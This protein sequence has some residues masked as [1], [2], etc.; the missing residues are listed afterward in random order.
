MRLGSFTTCTQ[1]IPGIPALVT[2]PGGSAEHCLDYQVR[3]R[4]D[5]LAATASSLQL[6]V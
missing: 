4:E 3:V 5:D 1:P 6:A 2:G